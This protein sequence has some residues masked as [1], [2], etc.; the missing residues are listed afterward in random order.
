[1]G[2]VGKSALAIH[3]AHRAGERFPD[4][5]L[6]ADLQS[7]T[8]GLPALSPTVVLGRFL[9]ALGIDG[10][11]IPT[12]VEEASVKFRAVTAG[13]RVLVVLD[14]AH[15]AVQVRPLLPTSPT[16][17]VVVTSRQVLATLDSAVN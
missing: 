2:G 16:C 11:D 3:A 7:G 6:Y 5:Q 13:R 12:S 15:D 4:G 1:I 10:G 14:N 17:A 8:A 9:R